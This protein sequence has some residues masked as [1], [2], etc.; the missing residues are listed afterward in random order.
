MTPMFVPLY[1]GRHQLLPIKPNQKK[2]TKPMISRNGSGRSAKTFLYHLINRIFKG[3]LHK[4]RWLSNIVLL[5]IPGPVA[6]FGF[7]V[8][9]RL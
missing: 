3:M 4:K 8:S 1:P 9:S 2:A 5:L 6:R 7:S